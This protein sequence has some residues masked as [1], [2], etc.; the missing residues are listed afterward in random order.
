[1]KRSDHAAVRR[2]AGF[3]ERAG[4]HGDA[5]S[6][7]AEV[8]PSSPLSTKRSAMVMRSEGPDDEFFAG[9]AGQP[10]CLRARRAAQWRR[11]SVIW[12]S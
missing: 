3:V 12:A 7:I 11:C 1:M 9:A 10:R 5:A 4:S 8:Q 2:E 6:M